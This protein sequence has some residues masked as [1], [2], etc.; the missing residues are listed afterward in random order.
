V[1]PRSEADEERTAQ[2]I[3][4]AFNNIFAGMHSRIHAVKGGEGVARFHATLQKDTFQRVTI[5][6]GVRF[7]TDGTVPATQVLQNAA[8]V[9]QPE[10]LARLKGSLD[11]LLAQQVL[12]MDTSYAPEDKKAISDLISKEKSRLAAF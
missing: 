4:A 9:P 6:S 11:R 7:G 10:R 3:V 12:Q 8:K 5:F 2:D 1:A